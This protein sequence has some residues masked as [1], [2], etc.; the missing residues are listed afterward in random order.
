VTFADVQARDRRGLRKHRFRIN[1]VFD[2]RRATLKS[3]QSVRMLVGHPVD[4]RLAVPLD[5]EAHIGGEL[6][7]SR[8]TLSSRGPQ[9][10]EVV[11]SYHVVGVCITETT[12]GPFHLV[13]L[14]GGERGR[15]LFDLPDIEALRRL[16]H[17]VHTLVTL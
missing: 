13:P 8:V 16:T 4:V 10:D 3:S 1:E 12:P 11:S 17:Y 6:R 14:A 9:C 7:K 2:H 5:R 15:E